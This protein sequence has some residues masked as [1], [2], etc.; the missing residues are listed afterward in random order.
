MRRVPCGVSV[1]RPASLSTLRCCDTA[2]R[3]TG[4]PAA[5]SPTAAGDRPTRSNT[6]RRVGSASAVSAVA[7]RLAMTYGKSMLTVESSLWSSCTNLCEIVWKLH[8]SDEYLAATG[9]QGLGRSDGRRWALRII[10]RLCSRTDQARP[11]SRRQACPLARGDRSGV[12]C[13]GQRTQPEVH[14]RGE[15]KSP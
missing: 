3:E 13:P 7:I 2:G 11:G 10:Q 15:P 1:T 8:G 14:L 5:I 12:G 9:A 6:A 4:S